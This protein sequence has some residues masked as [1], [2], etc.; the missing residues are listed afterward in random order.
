MS[1]ANPPVPNGADP[2][3]GQPAQPQGPLLL[4]LQYTKDLSFEVP[5]APE[6]FTTLREQPRIDLQLDVQAR[7]LQDGGNV[8]EV[9]LNIR[10]ELSLSGMRR[11]LNGSPAGRSISLTTVSTVIFHHGAKTRRQ[12]CGRANRA[13]CGL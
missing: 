3:A 9:S 11:L 5:G 13:M 6:I 4:N 1:E 12:S 8:F 10:A 7:A 2:A